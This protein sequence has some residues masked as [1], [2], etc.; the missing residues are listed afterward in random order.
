[1]VY[2][3]CRFD[4]AQVVAD[5]CMTMLYLSTIQCTYAVHNTNIL[6]YV[7]LVVT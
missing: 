4:R 7:E 3:T 5:L 6:C 2:S 1:M